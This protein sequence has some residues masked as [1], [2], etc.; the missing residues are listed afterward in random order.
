[1]ERPVV[2]GPAADVALEGDFRHGGGQCERD[3]S[4]LSDRW[5][6]QRQ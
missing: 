3:N 2:G 5:D 4:N 6:L 1:V